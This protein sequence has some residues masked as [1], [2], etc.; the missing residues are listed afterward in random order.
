MVKQQLV[1]YLEKA[2]HRGL[3]LAQAKDQLTQAGNKKEDVEE[4][5]SKVRRK[6]FEEVGAI[7]LGVII[8]IGL[9]GLFV[10]KYYLKDP[11]IEEP[12]SSYDMLKEAIESG[13]ISACDQFNPIK[14][15]IC[16]KTI[17]GELGADNPA[18]PPEYESVIQQAVEQQDPLLC[19][20]ITNA[21]QKN[22]CLIL[23]GAKEVEKD[24]PIYFDNET[25]QT[26]TEFEIIEDV[27]YEAAETGD[28]SLCDQISNPVLKQRCFAKS[29]T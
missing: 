14:K 3:T 29:Q 9:L 26:K 19:E 28:S 2:T 23:T 16:Q 13:D 7:V 10:D 22:R 18:T 1:D 24:P 12:K 21:I 4:A 6:K 11:V 5:A 20:Q 17:L 25:N 15:N 27:T 8:V